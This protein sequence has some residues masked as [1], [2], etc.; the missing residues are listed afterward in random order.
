MM[1][2]GFLNLPYL[3]GFILLMNVIFSSDYASYS[4]GFLRMGTTARSI[5][6]GSGFTAELDQGFTAYHN[7]A[8]IS[9]VT[10]RQASVTNHSLQLDRNFYVAS[11]ETNLPP[12]AGIGIAWIR[13]GVNQI[14]GRTEEGEHTGFLSTSEDAYFISFGQKLRPWLSVGINIKLLRLQLPMNESGL[15]GS[16][17]GFDLGIIIRPS[18][19]L[20]IGLVIQDLNSNYLWQT[21]EV[22]AEQG[23]IYKEQFPVIYRIGTNYRSK[24]IYF[25]GDFGV[26]TD[27]EDILGVPIRFG[28]EYQYKENYFF[29]AGYGNSRVSLGVG[30][31][32]ILFNE[33]DS[34]IDYAF[35]TEPALN[36]AHVFTVSIQ[37]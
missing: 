20:S 32:Y 8:G 37:F 9:F 28:G 21:S 10:K 22:F 19:P 4:G 29:R 31:K 27:Y 7:P 12:T 3:A 6:M 35:V 5:A 34:S 30:M 25:V 36:F 15:V 24:R 18:P 2:T 17:M 13:A 23:R 11:F 14:D 26:I 33:K 16:G 1:R